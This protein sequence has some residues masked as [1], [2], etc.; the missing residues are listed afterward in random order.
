MQITDLIPGILLTITK[1]VSDRLTISYTYTH[2]VFPDPGKKA[3]LSGVVLSLTML[4]QSR[5]LTAFQQ[6]GNPL[7]QLNQGNIENAMIERIML[8]RAIAVKSRYHDIMNDN[9]P[10]IMIS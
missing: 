5:F 1:L 7:I 10:N 8:W 9:L 2:N 3:R 6:D 4:K